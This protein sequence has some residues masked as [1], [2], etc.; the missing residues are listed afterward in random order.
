MEAKT[1]NTAGWLFIF[2]VGAIF[3][4][5]RGS[6]VDA[7]IYSVVALLV[8]LSSQGRFQIPEFEA[9]RFPNAAFLLL[10]AT[11]VF[12]FLPTHSWQDAAVFLIL[13]PILVRIIWQRDFPAPPEMSTA[14]RRS[15][16]IWIT[17]GLLTCVCE[18]GNYFASDL[19]HNDKVYPTITVLLD[20]IVADTW[21][22]VAFVTIWAGIGA[23][24][25]RVSTKRG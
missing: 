7:V 18:L 24:L 9:T 4:L 14:L 11:L 12:I 17:I 16:K 2:V 13:L 3:Q 20:P 19:V 22:K 15:S 1:R 8:F 25:L 10:V 23:G 6:S 21:G 5:W